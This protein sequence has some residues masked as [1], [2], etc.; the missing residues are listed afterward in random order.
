MGCVLAEFATVSTDMVDRLHDQNE[1]RKI[2]PHFTRE[3]FEERNRTLAWPETSHLVTFGPN[4]WS[5]EEIRLHP[6]G[7]GRKA[8]LGDD[9]RFSAA[10]IRVDAGSRTDVV[11]S[12]DRAIAVHVGSG[13]GRLLLGTAE[14]LHA[15]PPPSLPAKAGDLF[16]VAPGAHYAFVNDGAAPLVVAEHRIPPDVAFV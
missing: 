1:G 14:E 12:P 6:I 11:T 9:P 5:R 8:T 2:P 7:G 13:S 10:L 15:D 3:F 16:L 4:G